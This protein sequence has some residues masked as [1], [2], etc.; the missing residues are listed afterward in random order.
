MQKLPKKEPKQ[1]EVA[2]VAKPKKVAKKAPKKTTKKK[3]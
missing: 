3:S 2:E 1:H